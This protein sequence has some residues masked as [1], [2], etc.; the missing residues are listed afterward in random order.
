MERVSESYRPCEQP[1][2]AENQDAVVTNTSLQ[3]M[4]KCML[5]KISEDNQNLQKKMSEDNQNFPWLCVTIFSS[6][7]PII[8]TYFKN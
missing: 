3:H 2:E 1:D 8:N 7:N 4:F 5:E 6:N